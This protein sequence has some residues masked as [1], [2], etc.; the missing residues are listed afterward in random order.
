MLQTLELSVRGGNRDLLSGI[1]TRFEPG[2]VNLII[3]P[4]GAG[5]STLI[6]ALSGQA[7]IA[8]GKVLMNGKPIQSYSPQELARRR[9]VLSQETGLAFPLTVRE[10][11]LM[12]R[13]PHFRTAP[14]AADLSAARESMEVFGVT[15]LSERNYLTLSGGEKQRVQFARVLAQLWYGDDVSQYL[16]LDEPLTFLDIYFQVRFMEQIRELA[17]G[18]KWVIIGVVHDLNL[19]SKYADRIFLLKDGRLLSEGKPTEVLTESN[20]ELAYG[21][22]PYVF[23]HDGVLRL[24]F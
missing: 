13:Y 6:R 4:N 22:R 9:A 10:V 19:A 7:P 21:L 1:T 14:A 12:G 5:K 24:V 16:L 11:V 3:G 15:D 18:K 23:E 8:G 17:H 2:M 20:I